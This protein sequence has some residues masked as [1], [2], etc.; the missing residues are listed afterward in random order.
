MYIRFIAFSF[1]FDIL[2][3]FIY[4]AKILGM[5][6]EFFLNIVFLK[7]YPY[8]IRLKILPVNRSTS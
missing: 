8:N 7:P 2:K 3:Y 1:F 5:L 4:F 6:K